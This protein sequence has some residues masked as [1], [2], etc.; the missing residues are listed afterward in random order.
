MTLVVSLFI[1]TIYKFD[2]RFYMRRIKG[3]S[4]RRKKAM[5]EPSSHSEKTSMV[6]V[7]AVYSIQ[8]RHASYRQTY[9][10]K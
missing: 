3:E 1:I 5:Q 9:E 2:T 10:V 6:R 4:S 8:G 7:N